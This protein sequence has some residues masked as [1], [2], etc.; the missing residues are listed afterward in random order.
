MLSSDHHIALRHSQLGHAIKRNAFDARLGNLPR[1]GA[2]TQGVTKDDLETKHGSFS[3]RT[4]MMARFL[5]PS[6]AT[7]TM[8][9]T[10]IL[11]A[12]Q[13]RLGRVPVLPD[14]GVAAGG[15]R[16]AVYLVLGAGIVE[17]TLI[18]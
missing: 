11:V 6:F 15:H 8:N 1:Q 14:T 4:T 18:I 17:F 7:D 10:Q 5:L 9:T 2:R 3:Q 12:W 13:G 16:N